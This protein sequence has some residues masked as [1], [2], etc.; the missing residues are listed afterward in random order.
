MSINKSDIIY[1]DN[2]ATTPI[3]PDVYKEMKPYLQERYGNPNSLHIKGR[4]AKQAIEEAREKVASLINADTKEIIFTS[5][6]TESNNQAIKG[7]VNKTDK[8]GHI[9]TTKTEHKSII[10]PIKHLEREGHEVTYLNVDK[11]GY[12]NPQELKKAI[13]E[14]TIL[15]SIHYANNEIGTIQPIKKLAK[16]TPKDIPFHTDAAQIPGKI[17]INVKNLEIDLLTINGHKMYGPKGIGALW[18]NKKTKIQPLLHGGGQ[19][20]NRRSGTENVPYIVGFGKAA[21]KAKESL[22]KE[23]KKLTEMHEKILTQIPQKIENTKI[24][25]PQ[26]N[27]L[28]GNANISFK[29]I[30]GEALVLRLEDKGIMA[31]TGSACASETLEPS[32][33]LI[34]TGV[35]EE[36]AHS[37]LRIS[38]GRFNEMQDVEKIIETLPEEVKKLRS[39]SAV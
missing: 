7:I 15:V 6:A 5:C 24:N 8:K 36:L 25:G 13:K 21:E 29:G 2:N 31:S 14:N 23:Q 39:I 37:S 3:D 28:P 10:N 9:I 33:V 38:F 34:E 1:A 17:D 18:I 4:E 26:K 35:P 11:N 19:E 27:R 20:N 32:H 12:V 22:K 16:T 30:E